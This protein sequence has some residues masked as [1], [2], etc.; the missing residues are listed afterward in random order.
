M[1]AEGD[2]SLIDEV[3]REG[4]EKYIEEER[5][6]YYVAMTRAKERLFITNPKTIISKG[7]EVPRKP[8]RF[9]SEIPDKY[10]LEI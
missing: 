2:A 4:F 7:A 10:A 6:L 9:L 1:I 5:R 8:S 3:N